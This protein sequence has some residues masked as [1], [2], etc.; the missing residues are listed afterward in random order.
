MAATRPEARRNT[1]MEMIMKTKGMTSRTGDAIRLAVSFAL[2]AVSIIALFA[3]PADG[4]PA[5]A[6]WRTV[7]ASKAVALVTGYFGIKLY[8]GEE[9]HD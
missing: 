6:W 2:M 4:L 5:A 1:R 7:A 9:G 3:V 8:P